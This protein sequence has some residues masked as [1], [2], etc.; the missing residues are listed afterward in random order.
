M[1][2]TIWTIVLF[3]NDFNGQ[4]PIILPWTVRGE[5]FRGGSVHGVTVLGHLV[6]G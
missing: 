2:M 1:S 6:L 4:G 5:H 3:S